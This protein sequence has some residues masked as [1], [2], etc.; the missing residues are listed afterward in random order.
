MRLWPF[1]RPRPPAAVSMAPPSL[2]ERE[3][4]GA[5]SEGMAAADEGK[6]AVEAARR[7]LDKEGA[8]LDLWGSGRPAKRP[9]G[10]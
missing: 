1:K 10:G 7:Q 6:R 3:A 8:L 9:N 2:R 4:Y 5:I